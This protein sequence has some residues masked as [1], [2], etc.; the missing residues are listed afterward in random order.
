MSNPGPARKQADRAYKAL[1]AAQGLGIDA[2]R[3]AKATGLT[4]M[5]CGRLLDQFARDGLAESDDPAGTANDL[6]RVFR[7]RAALGADGAAHRSQ[8]AGRML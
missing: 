3:L 1:L 2:Y 5:H 6:A 8:V 4:V 7:P